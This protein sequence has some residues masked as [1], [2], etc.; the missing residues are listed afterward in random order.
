MPPPLLLFRLLLLGRPTMPRRRLP[1]SFPDPDLR[2]LLTAATNP[3]DRLLLELGVFTGLRVGEMVMLEISDIDWHRRQLLVRRGKGDK[4]RVLPIP[5]KVIDRL[6][7]WLG[8]RRT[9][10]VFPS[11]R[12]K[13]HLTTRAIQ[14][15]IKRIA[16][17]AGLAEPKKP[18]RITPHRLRHTF[19]T[20]CLRRGA[21]I[22]EV[23]DL[24]GHTSV[25]TTQVYLSADPTR[26]HKAVERAALDDDAA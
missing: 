19:A 3:R 26:L 17:A 14:K 5:H 4:D 15:L 22:I 13:S 10:Y 20:R 16:A 23:R 12:G 2:A 6:K 18:R 8:N 9:G 1:R 25:S 11:P 21:D 7:T 24:L